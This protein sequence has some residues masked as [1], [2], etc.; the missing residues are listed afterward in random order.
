MQT[1]QQT[2]ALRAFEHVR[3]IAGDT[4]KELRKTYSRA[5][6]RFPILIR[7][8]GLQQTLG[9]YEGKAAT[10]SGKAEKKFLEQISEALGL[11]NEPT[12][13]ILAATL[14]QYLFYTRR[15]LE[16]A[17]WYRRF[18]DSMLDDTEGNPTTD[19]TEGE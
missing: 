14:P 7:Q 8:N 16:I 13:K 11:S 12:R 9:F 17:I 3:E 18:A 10:K 5:V 19:P 2:D 15:C 6:M 4:D 1:R